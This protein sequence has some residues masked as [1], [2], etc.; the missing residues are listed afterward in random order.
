MAD[1]PTY[2]YN[3]HFDAA[4]ATVW[5]A[6]SDPALLSVWY[7]PG[8]D[9]IIHE[10]DL[11]PGGV[12]KNEMKWGDK[13]DLSRMDF[14]EVVEGEK[15]VW[16]H[17]SADADWNVAANPMMPNW[18]RVLLTTVTFADAEGGTKVQLTQVPVDANADE[19]A[20]FAEMMSNMDH[21]WGKG[22]DLI[23]NLL[24]DL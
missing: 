18:P 13:S 8:V 21:G 17:S 19:L 1:L 20:C 14:L 10:F 9:T 4:R 24:A 2:I 3:R 16:N 23:E 6:W 7:G 15:L 5:R 22:F 11:R 12:W